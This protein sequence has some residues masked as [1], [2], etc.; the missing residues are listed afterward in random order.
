MKIKYLMALVL[1]LLAGSSVFAQTA[2]QPAGAGA[3]KMKVAIIDVLAFR[4]EVLELKAKY[5]KLQAE[6][7]PKYRE[8]EAMQNQIGAKQK[9]LEGNKAL[10]PQQGQKLVEEIEQLKKDYNRALE[11]SQTRA[12]KR[13][14]EET[15]AIYEKLDKALNQYCAKYGITTVFDARK[16]QETGVIV[17]VKLPD[18]NITPDFI[19]EYNKANPVQ[20]AAAP[21]K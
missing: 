1:L 18:A 14:T 4:E 21:A 6:F 9:V 7:A 3:P 20:A 8:L 5:E 2:A 17:H 11:D 10:T 19:K 15:E 12:R 13:E 16:L